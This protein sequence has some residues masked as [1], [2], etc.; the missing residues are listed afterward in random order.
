MLNS[1]SRRVTQSL[2]VKTTKRT[3]QSHNTNNYLTGAD[4]MVLDKLRYF[5]VG[6]GLA[7]MA[8]G[9]GNLTGFGLHYLM[10]PSNYDY[11]FH[12]RG[13]GKFFQ[14]IKSL[15]GCESIMN[16]WAP[17]AL[18]GGGMLAQ[19]SMGSLKTAKFFGMCFAGTY[20]FM[21]SFGPSNG[22]GFAS[23][24]ALY[25]K[26]GLNITSHA[27]CGSYLCGSDSMALGLVT[28]IMCRYGMFVPALAFTAGA[29]AYYGPQGIGGQSAA[30]AFAAFVL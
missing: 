23:Q 1:A 22:S 5:K 29:C 2:V 10:K 27:P 28:L 3:F 18:I 16:L 7:F 15:F 11:Y 25:N 26:L 21:S 14:P 20:G 6:G 12:Y 24:F 19:S 8:L 13:A 4:R 17:A 30:L 9:A